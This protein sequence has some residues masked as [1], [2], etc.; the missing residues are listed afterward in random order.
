MTTTEDKTSLP[1]GPRWGDVEEKYYDL[2]H[3]WRIW[4]KSHKDGDASPIPH[5][6]Q[7]VLPRPSPF[8]NLRSEKYWRSVAKPVDMEKRVEAYKTPVQDR[9]I[10]LVEPSFSALERQLEQ[11]CAAIGPISFRSAFAGMPKDTSPGYPLNRLG[12]VEKRQC[13]GLLK[14]MQQ[15]KRLFKHTH[16]IDTFPVL[17]GARNQLCEIGDNKPRLTWVY[18]MEVAWLEATFALPLF[19]RLKKCSVLAWDINWF[20]GGASKLFDAASGPGACFG[21]DF[22]GFDASVLAPWIRR[23]FQVLERL[24][25]F[26]EQWQ[27]N[28]WRF[29]V[30]YFV[31][32]WLIMYNTAHYI[33]RGVPSGSFFTQVID[34]IVNAIAHHDGCSRLIKQRSGVTATSWYDVFRYSKFLGDDS[35]IVLGI[36]LYST[37]NA[38]LSMDMERRHNL[39]SHA[40]KG[41]WIPAP[42]IWDDD[43]ADIVRKDFLGKV[44]ISRADVE[45]ETDLLKAQ[46]SIPDSKDTGPGDYMT[47]LIGLAWAKGTNWLQHRMLQQEFD[48]WAT[49]GYVP[50][51]PRKGEIRSLFQ[52]VLHAEFPSLQFP[53]WEQVKVRYAGKAA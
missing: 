30:D 12:Y 7:S 26:E 47:R 24:I 5:G 33:R 34:S 35:Y 4:K 44:L 53:P 45:I 43:D 48:R 11:E 29:I 39:T 46:A 25:I 14:R 1:A 10:E 3:K 27:R 31:D 37:D 17:A 23:A 20:E 38:V 22:S 52:Q 2:L 42:Q 16:K 8:S 18:P 13:F 49:K 6:I 36:P 21:K 19:E 40:D 41:F 50:T 32:K 28:A 15:L 51:E 9:S